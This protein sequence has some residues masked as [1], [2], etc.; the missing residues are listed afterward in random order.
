M[1]EFRRNI[2]QRES[3]EISPEKDP[4]SGKYL[5]KLR[6]LDD[7]PYARWG[8]LIGEIVHNTRSPLD[9]IVCA[10][11]MS[12]GTNPDRKTAFPVFADP[13]DYKLGFVREGHMTRSYEMSGARK[14]VGVKRRVAA[15]IQGLQPYQ[16]HATGRG[17]F[18]LDQ[19]WRVD[20]HLVPIGGVGRATFEIGAA[21]AFTEDRAEITFVPEEQFPY[22]TGATAATSERPMDV[23]LRLAF[24]VHF[25]DGPPWDRKPRPFGGLPVADTL[26]ACVQAAED[27]FGKLAPFITWSPY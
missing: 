20:K 10:L 12:N 1:T 8:V 22:E 15:E 2:R 18:L 13:D 14:I 9:Q 4:D 27:T 23:H 26:T 3:F 7:P 21:A 24:E 19:L 25:K 16:Q 17:L 5:H 11:C 6:V